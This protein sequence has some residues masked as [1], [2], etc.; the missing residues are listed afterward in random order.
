LAMAQT[1]VVRGVMDRVRQAEICEAVEN[2]QSASNFDPRSASKID[3]ILERGAAGSARPGGA[4]L[5]CAAGASADGE[6]FCCEVR[7]GS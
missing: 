5:G 3:P 2:C 4:G 7:R 1:D 6:E